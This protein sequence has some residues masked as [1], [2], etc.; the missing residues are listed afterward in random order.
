MA[1][2]GFIPSPEAVS[3]LDITEAQAGQR[4]DNFLLALLKGVPR[5]RIYRL[6]RKGEVRVN[7]GRIG[8]DYKLLAGDRLRVPPVRTAPPRTSIEPPQALQQQLRD[9]VQS[10][11]AGWL[12]LDK[13]AGLA[14]HGGSG[15]ALGVIEAL[16]AMWSDERALELV[17]RLDRDTSG[18]LLVA[19]TRAALVAL[20]R[21][22][23][24]GAME[25]NYLAL[26]A[27][28]WPSGLTEVNAPLK[29]NTLSSGERIVRAEVGGKPAL[30]R[31]RVVQRLP[32]F[33]LLEARLAT[34]R[35]HQIRVHCQ[36]LGHPI[37]G[38]PK[39]GSR[40]ADRQAREF[41]LRRLFLHAAELIFQD[42]AQ[43][44]RVEGRAPLPADLAEVLRR[45]A[46]QD[47]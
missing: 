19:T 21:Q 29:K 33:T 24:D 6:L 12:V 42:P 9:R 10:R 11:G 20:Q 40:D 32:G 45:M 30:T 28:S 37:A 38:D 36:L 4:V 3:W 5:S 8:P 41:G 39:Y 31:F 14:V 35:T 7:K 18:C 46:G 44:V 43:G 1:D 34:G 15:V 27:G 26:V 25:K 17:H 47:G 2:P 23:R 13:P 22:M 16:R